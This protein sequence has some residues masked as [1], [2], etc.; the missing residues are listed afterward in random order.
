MLDSRWR[1]RDRIS[2]TVPDPPHRSAVAMIPSGHVAYHTVSCPVLSDVGC[3]IG[4]YNDKHVRI[5]VQTWSKSVG[6]HRGNSILGLTGRLAGGL[7]L[8]SDQ[9]ADVSAGIFNLF[10]NSQ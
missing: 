1:V 4:E 10:L 9:M 8:R 7:A 3:Y 2:R 6:K 5:I